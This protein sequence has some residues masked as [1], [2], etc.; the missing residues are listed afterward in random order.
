MDITKPITPAIEPSC[1]SVEAL[2]LKAGIYSQQ[3]VFSRIDGLVKVKGIVTKI[4]RY[5][6][7]LSNVERSGI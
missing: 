5:K 6:T 7:A 3:K 2:L 4:N 1:Y